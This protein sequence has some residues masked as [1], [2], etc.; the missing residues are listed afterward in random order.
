MTTGEIF[1]VLALKGALVAVLT[2]FDLWPDWEA[3]AKRREEDKKV[4]RAYHE[5]RKNA[6]PEAAA[7]ASAIL[8]R[9]PR[10]SN[11]LRAVK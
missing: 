10:R 8:D 7:E 3:R 9:L 5:W 11:N 6:G 1:V 4:L 2:Y